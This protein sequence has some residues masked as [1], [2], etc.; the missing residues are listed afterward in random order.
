MDADEWF[1]DMQFP[2]DDELEDDFDT[3]NGSLHYDEESGEYHR[4]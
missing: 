3:L 1:Y 2:E 4:V